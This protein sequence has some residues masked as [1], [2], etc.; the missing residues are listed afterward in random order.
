MSDIDKLM[1]NNAL[2]QAQRDRAEN[3]RRKAE[4]EEQRRYEEEMQ[5][6]QHRHDLRLAIF[7]LLAGAVLSNFDRVLDLI[8][9]GLEL[10]SQA[11]S[12]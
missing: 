5:K 1:L 8:K 7:N 4:S 6:K 12:R 11:I 2:N 9:T 10:L 3:A